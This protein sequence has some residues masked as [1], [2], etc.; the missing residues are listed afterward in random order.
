VLHHRS[1]WAGALQPQGI[2]EVIPLGAERRRRAVDRFQEDKKV[3][4]LVGGQ[5]VR[6]RGHWR[7]ILPVGTQPVQREDFVQGLGLAAVQ[8]RCA[9]VETEQ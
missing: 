5:R 6:N 2:P 8:V 3:R 9:I 4:L 7:E 1:H